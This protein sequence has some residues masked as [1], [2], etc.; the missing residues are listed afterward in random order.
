MPH[1]F[2]YGTLQQPDVQLAT[3]GRHLTGQT[4]ELMGYEQSLVAIDD[5][6]VVALSGKTHHPIVKYTGEPQ[7]RVAGI[8]FEVTEVEL[9]Q[10]DAYEVAAYQ[11]VAAELASGLSTWVYVDARF[12]PNK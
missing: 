12:V 9:A 11:R 6:E 4:D 1:L 2:S 5:A 8:V 3:F 10:A 7:H